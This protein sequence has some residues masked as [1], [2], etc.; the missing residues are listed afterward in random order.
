MSANA[1]AA[2]TPT[3]PQRQSARQHG[4]RLRTTANQWGNPTANHGNETQP[5]LIEGESEGKPRDRPER[6]VGGTT[7]GMS[8]NAIAEVAMLQPPHS[9]PSEKALEET[10]ES[11]KA[12][13]GEPTAK[14]RAEG[15][16]SGFQWS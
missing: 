15:K 7:G 11:D 1:I 10:R 9:P 16:P 6:C 12:Q 13:R 4:Q 2:A 3:H 14:R 8:A 5:A